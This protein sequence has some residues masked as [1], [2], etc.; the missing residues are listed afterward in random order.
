ML[1]GVIVIIAGYILLA[2]GASADPN[3]FSKDIFDW[4]RLVAAPIVILAG[5]AVVIVSI[6]GNFR[7]KEDK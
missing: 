5:I 1:A 6:L 2:G 7:D 4:R 3:V